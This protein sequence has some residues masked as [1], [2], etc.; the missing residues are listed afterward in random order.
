VLGTRVIS[1]LLIRNNLFYSS[2]AGQRLP[3]AGVRVVLLLAATRPA[4]ASA[5]EED[6]EREHTDEKKPR[7][8]RLGD[9]SLVETLLNRLQ[10][11]TNEECLLILREHRTARQ[12]AQLQAGRLREENSLL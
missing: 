3:R 9:D 11:L 6:A 12:N 7:P 8:G 1:L 10:L 4:G 5:T 2:S